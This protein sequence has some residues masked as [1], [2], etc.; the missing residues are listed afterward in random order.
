ADLRLDR[1]EDAFRERSGYAVI[2]PAKVEE[3][4]LIWRVT[5]DDPDEV[6]PPPKS[7][8]RLDAK[9]IQLLRRWVS[10]GAKWEGHWS[11]V[12]PA[13]VPQPPV[14]DPRW[15]R[16]PIDHF[17]LARLESAGL[18][19]SPEADRATLIRRVSLDLI[20]LPPTPGEVDV[21][22]EDLSSD[23]YERV[24]DRLLASPHHGER[25]ARTW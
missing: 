1:K 12:L 15:P 11:Y 9:Q 17:V 4:E 21:F 2:V 3:S 19:P 10:E 18:R 8:K 23:A 16:N 7:K 14:N 5:S 20:G 6:M 22:E 13:S 25:Q 24:V